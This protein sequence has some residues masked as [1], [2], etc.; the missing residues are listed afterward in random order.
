MKRKI[1]NFI[2]HPKTK[3]VF[4][5]MKPERS[6]VGFFGIV[7][8]FI[9]PEIIAFIWGEEITRFAQAQLLLTPTLVMEYYFKF[10]IMMF[11]EGGS[12]IN[13]ILGFGLLIWLFF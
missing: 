11:S 2:T 3:Q 13:L 7:L 9:L 6:L 1:K 10:L 4:I 8:L 12:W 5:S